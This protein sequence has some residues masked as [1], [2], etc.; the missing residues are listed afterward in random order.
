MAHRV[1]SPVFFC[2][3]IQERFRSA[4]YGFDDMVGACV[5]LV[6]AAELFNF[7]IIATEQNPRALGPTISEL[8]LPEATPRFPKTIFSMFIS[9]VQPLLANHDAVVI[10]GLESHVCVLQTTLDLRA[11]GYKV[12]VV[13]DAVS[14]CNKEEIPIALARMRQAGAIVTTSESVL[15]E[16]LSDASH[17]K[18]KLFS[19]LIKESKEGTK[20][21]LQK[22]VGTPNL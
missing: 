6:K 11:E 18:F 1:K 10:F 13:A 17:P 2:C 16:L 20:A 21:S 19:G 4:I 22:L 8:H 3:D 15:F 14:S 12:Y 5:K 7:P 9:D